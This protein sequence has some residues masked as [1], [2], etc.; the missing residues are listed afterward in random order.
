MLRISKHESMKEYDFYMETKFPLNLT[1]FIIEKLLNK[2]VK[3]PE[4]WRSMYN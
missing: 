2:K 3:E 1:P 4:A